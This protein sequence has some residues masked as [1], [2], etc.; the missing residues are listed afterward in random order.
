VTRQTAYVLAFT[1][2]CALAAYLLPAVP[3]PLAYH[4]FADHRPLFGIANFLDVASNIGFLLA[5]IAGLAIVFRPAT[6]FASDRERWPY[7]VFFAG[8]LLT[9]LGSAYYHLVPENERLFW[10]RLPMTIAFMS[11][12][13]AQVVDRVSLHAGLTLLLPMLLLGAASVVYWRATERVGAGNLTPYAILQAYAVLMLLLL[14]VLHPSRYTHG[15]D[16]YGVIGAYAIAK[17]LETFDRHLLQVGNVVS[18]HTLKHLAAAAGG[19]LVCRMLVVRTLSSREA[20]S[21]R[22]D[23]AAL[24]G[25]S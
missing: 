15:N 19:L 1:A 2:L 3:Q 14:A 23:V 8:M 20:Q 13:A 25:T 17:L 11:L 24:G 18:G 6:P 12:I 9:A 5:G 16:L 10:D 21:A 22:Q 7:A 4:D